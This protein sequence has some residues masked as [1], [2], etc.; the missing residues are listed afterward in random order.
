MPYSKDNK[1]GVVVQNILDQMP[2]LIAVAVVDINTGMSLASHSNSASLN[3]D[4]A[5]AYNAEV[6]KQKQKAMAAL[7]LTGESLDDILITLS[8][9]IHLIK[10][11]GTTNKFIYLAAN[12][13][14]TNLAIARE[15]LRE[16]AALL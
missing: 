12:S 14:D 3:P 16:Q 6:V 15:I 13:R 1:F 11:I 10:V 9:Q 5:A 2:S 7:K 8:N 4:S